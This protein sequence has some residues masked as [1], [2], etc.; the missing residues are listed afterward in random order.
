MRTGRLHPPS[1]RGLTFFG[2]SSY[3]QGGAAA[4]VIDR[5]DNMSLTDVTIT[6]SAATGLHV[7]GQ[8]SPGA[9]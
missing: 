4:L 9:S 5:A 3:H 1:V 7:S 2:F 8:G 6:D